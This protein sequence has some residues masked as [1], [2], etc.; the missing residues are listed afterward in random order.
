MFMENISISYSEMVRELSSVVV[1]PSHIHTASS[2]STII[3]AFHVFCLNIERSQICTWAHNILM[4]DCS[5]Y[6]GLGWP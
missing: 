2:F 1:L 3:L 4:F 5:L 6:D